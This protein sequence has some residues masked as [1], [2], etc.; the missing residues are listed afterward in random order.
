MSGPKAL[1]AAAL[2]LILVAS[3][4]GAA[5]AAA[6]R[7]ASKAAP[8]ATGQLRGVNLTPNWEWPGGRGMDEA[9][10]AREI[11]SACDLGADLVRFTV[12]WNRIEP[13]QGRIDEGYVSRFDQVLSQAG[14]CGI[15]VLVTLINTPCW[16]AGD[17]A[18]PCVPGAATLDPPRDPAE[19]GSIVERVLARWPGIYALEVRNEPNL[20]AFFHG[21]PADYAALANAAVAGAE[22][23]GAGTQILVGSVGGA[24]A[25]YL[26]ELYAAGIHGYDGIS[27]HPY[28]FQM[29]GGFTR[30]ARW[31]NHRSLFETRV[32]AIHQSMLAAGDHSGLWLTEFGYSVCPTQPYCVSEGRQSRSLAAS[33]RL[34]AGW[35]YVRGLTS[36]DLR[37]AGDDSNVWDNRYGL[38]ARDFTPRRSYFAVRSM[39]HRLGG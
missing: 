18:T 10:S 30:T 36:Y 2:I 22:R 17:P 35:R 33:F 24:D 34:A 21:S 1:L 23:S 14:G 20:T 19:Y 15:R 26:R 11:Q 3:A 32:R 7:K 6:K 38:L 5:G 37:D 25:G 12:K 29:R 4:I 31:K 39:L 9:A 16:A 28:D 27:I 13:T 8:V